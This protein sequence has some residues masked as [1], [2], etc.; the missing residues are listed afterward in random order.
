MLGFIAAYDRARAVPFTREQHRRV[1]AWAVYCIAYGARISIAPGDTDWPQ[2]SWAAL[3]RDCGE[4][5]L[6]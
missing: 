6:A 4:R 3:L 2:D 5:R 1:R